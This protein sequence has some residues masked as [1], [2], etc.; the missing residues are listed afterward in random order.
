MSE[1]SDLIAGRYRL[2]R[3]LGQGSFAETHLAEDTALGRPVAIKILR[4]QYAQDERFALRFEREARAAAAVRHNNVVD[5][6]DYGQDEATLY[7]VMEWV[8]GPN[9]KEFLRGR[10]QLEPTE[11]AG[12]MRDVL[13]GLEAIHEAGIV[14]RDVKPQNVLVD[15]NGTAKLSDFGIARG[16]LDAGLTDTGM[17]LGTAA[18]MA[19]EQARAGEIGP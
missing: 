6:F 11:A 12:I 13:R 8:D 19:P 14:H 16:T 9:L 4:S 3:Q 7:L 2:T 17:A 18:Y 10:G 1:S 5:V 15:K